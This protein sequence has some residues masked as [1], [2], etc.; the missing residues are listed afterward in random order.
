MKPAAISVPVMHYLASAAAV[1]RFLDIGNG[2]PSAT[3]PTT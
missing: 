3:K 2:L 1:G